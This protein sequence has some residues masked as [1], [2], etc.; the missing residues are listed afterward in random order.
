MN[1]RISIYLRYVSSNLNGVGGGGE[2]NFVIVV[3]YHY[4]L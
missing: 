3:S 2:S 4:S 1:E